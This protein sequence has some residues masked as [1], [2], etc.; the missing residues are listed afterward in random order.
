[1]TG[2]GNTAKGFGALQLTTEGN[3]N[4]A[5]GYFSGSFSNKSLTGERNTFIGANTGYTNGTITNS[6]AIGADVILANSNTVILGNNANVGIGTTNPVYKLDVSG[7]ANLNNSIASGIA[8]RC[9]GAE[10]LWYNGTYFSWGHDATY[11]YFADPVTIGTAGAPGYTLV[12]NG[13]A[14]KTDGGSWSVLS[15]LRLKDLVGNYDKGLKEIL[16]LQAVRFTY[17]EGNSRQLTPDV[18]QIGF[19]AQDVQKIF[20]E[21]VD[22]CKDGYLDFNMHPVNV[23]MVN[24]IKELK[25]ENNDLKARLEKLESIIDTE[26]KR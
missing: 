23:A 9:N 26:A 14:A 21:A 19:I 12:V 13:T 15:D 1:T 17:K 11:N 20:P 5:I 4:T 10:A 3:Q 25:A 2:Y 6:T 16:D 22:E 8:M 7:T 24:A 18:E